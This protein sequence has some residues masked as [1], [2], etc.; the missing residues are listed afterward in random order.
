MNKSTKGK[1]ELRRVST[2]L[3]GKRDKAGRKPSPP[4]VN[5]RNV[6]EMNVALLTEQERKE[7]VEATWYAYEIVLNRI[8]F[9]KA[10]TK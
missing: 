9:P 2:N 5:T 7:L 4:R 1:T 6:F 10:A 8:R 3:G